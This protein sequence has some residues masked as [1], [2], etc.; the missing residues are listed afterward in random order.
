MNDSLLNTAAKRARITLGDGQT[1]LIPIQ[2]FKL[3][4][5]LRQLESGCH[6]VTLIKDKDSDT[7]SWAVYS[8]KVEG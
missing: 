3:L 5:R 6:T 8:A 4:L 7:V 2:W 1:Q